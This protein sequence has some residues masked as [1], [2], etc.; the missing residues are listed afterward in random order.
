MSDQ[1]S[2][3][4]LISCSH[5]GSTIDLRFF[6]AAQEFACPH[7]SG[8]I[9]LPGATTSHQHPDLEQREQTPLIQEK[10]QRKNVFWMWCGLSVLFI[11]VALIIAIGGFGEP[12]LTE[13]A[14]RG[15]A[16]AQYEMGLAARAV[17]SN[18]EGAA[19]DKAEAVK[20]F[21]K[22]AEQGHAEA[23]YSLGLSLAYGLGV[24]HDIEEAVKWFRK[25]AFR[26]HAEAEVL[27]R[28]GLNTNL[29]IEELQWRIKKYGDK[30]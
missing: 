8:L 24:R 20:W 6:S 23:Q 12:T 13:L 4:A 27:C 19:E 3:D 14:E 25:A 28:I 22:A 17:Y 9:A 7:C 21:R 18:G 30:R 15:D 29:P 26:G 16:Q 1:D 11:A 2:N 10:R 5:C